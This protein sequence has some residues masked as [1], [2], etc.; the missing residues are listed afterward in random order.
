M[1]ASRLKVP[2]VE[3]PVLTDAETAASKL[4]PSKKPG[5]HDAAVRPSGAARSERAAAAAGGLLRD[6]GPQLRRRQ[7]SILESGTRWPPSSVPWPLSNVVQFF[8]DAEKAGT[9]TIARE[10]GG[11]GGQEEEVEVAASCQLATTNEK[12][13]AAAR[14][15]ARPS[16]SLVVVRD[17]GRRN[18]RLLLR[19]LQLARGPCRTGPSSCRGTRSRGMSRRLP[20]RCTDPASGSDRGRPAR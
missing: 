1:A 4:I 16:Q 7:A 19:P 13:P 3:T 2:V 5:T 15:A 6:G 18:S 12:S 11:A 10:A 20:R 8:R 9:F 14:C 17:R